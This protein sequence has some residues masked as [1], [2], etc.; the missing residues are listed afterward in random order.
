MSF[1]PVCPTPVRSIPCR[2]AW[3]LRP[4]FSLLF[5]LFLLFC[6]CPLAAEAAAPHVGKKMAHYAR[7]MEFYY[8]EQR[9]EVLPGMLRAFEREGGLAKA[10]NRLMLAAFYAELLQ[11]QPS[12][13][14]TLL[15]AAPPLA[16]HG[17]HVL[18]WAA[19]LAQLPDAD[20]RI[21]SLLDRQDAALLRQLEHSPRQ[22]TAWNIWAEPTVQQL[23]WGSFMASGNAAC[24][25]S[26]IMAAL[27]YGP[28]QAAG[29]QNDPAFAVSAAVAATLYD[30]A[31]RHARI[32]QRLEALLP[33]VQGHEAE[34]VRTILRR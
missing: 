19:H 30:L 25:D 29:R 26:L 5:W 32:R 9:P 17:R 10:E 27:H 14:D 23:Y 28:L 2:P 22:I 16:R 24:L 12:L 3:W 31:P 20:K 34:V 13:F 33:T 18:A 6:P 11:R 21:L 7:D 1:C 15:A 8:L 4:G